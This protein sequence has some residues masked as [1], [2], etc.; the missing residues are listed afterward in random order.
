MPQQK[1]I[2]EL[3]KTNARFK[4]IYQEYQTMSDEL[5]DLECS[6]EISVTDDFL[7]SVVQQTNY[8]EDEIQDWLIDESSE[9]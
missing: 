9:E 6:S 8:L 5:W 4:R 7:N 2:E 3:E 1:R